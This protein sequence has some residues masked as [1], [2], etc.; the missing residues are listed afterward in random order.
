MKEIG[1]INVRDY[2]DNMSDTYFWICLQD[3]N[4]K[5][6]DFGLA[7]D[8]PTGD[9]SHVSTGIMGTNGYV[10][11]EYEESGIFRFMFPNHNFV[12]RCSGLA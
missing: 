10:D 5:I 12:S 2:L 11:P 4:A 7:R 1:L 8:G 9:K 3:Y 6:S